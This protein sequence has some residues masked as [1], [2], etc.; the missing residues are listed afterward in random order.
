M[1]AGIIAA[2]LPTLKP[3]AADFFGTV[4]AFT[5][6]DRYGSRVLTKGGSRLQPSNG[7][8]RQFEP[9][10]ARSYNMDDLKVSG[11]KAGP[12]RP[13][14]EIHGTGSDTYKAH[15]RRG[16]RAGDSDESNLLPQKG[17]IRTTEVEI[18]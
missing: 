6:G 5:P 15:G 4:S 11:E 3:L 9:G 1:N 12:E 10:A 8:L 13:H 17:I 16:S 7:Y 18:S 14:K 2:C